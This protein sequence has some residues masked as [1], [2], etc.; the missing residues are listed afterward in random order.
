[1]RFFAFFCV[2][3]HHTLSQPSSS[4]L[5]IQVAQQLSLRATFADGA[6]FAV[7]LFF[8]L[9]G[10]LI[11]TLLTIERE[12]TGTIHLPQ[13]YKRRIARI[14]PVYYAFMLL[15]GG[16][17]IAVP[18]TPAIRRRG[19]REP[20]IQRQLVPH[21]G[22][23]ERGRRPGNPL[24]RQH[25]R[26]VLP[27]V[28]S[29]AALEQPRPNPNRSRCNSRG[30]RLAHRLWNTGRDVRSGLTLQSIRRDAVLRRGR[31]AGGVAA[32]RRS[33]DPRRTSRAA[34]LHRPVPVDDRCTLLWGRRP[35]AAG[36]MVDAGRALRLRARSAVRQSSSASSASPPVQSH[37]GYAGWERSPTG[38]TSTTNWCS[39]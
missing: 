35:Q 19:D 18:A 38:S 34:G 3:L 36:R 33:E 16:I 28:A 7:S 31:S 2:F 15:V 11:T 17:G 20:L 25:R 12:Q 29:G 27:A 26:A 5:P 23:S 6:K 10:Y 39:P 4:R 13:F 32:A 22:W 14:W 9:S 8:L 37:R 30:V 24:E 21:P 1:M